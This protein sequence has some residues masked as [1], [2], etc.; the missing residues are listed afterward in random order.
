MI[1]KAFVEAFSDYQVQVDVPLWKLA[2]M[3]DRRSYHPELSYG[4]FLEGKLVGFVLNGYRMWQGIPTAYDVGTGV[5]PD[6]RRQ[7]LT[8]EML[9]RSKRAMRAAKIK[10]YLLEVI[11]T[12]ENAVKLY[13]EQGFQTIRTFTCFRGSVELIK[14]RHAAV[15]EAVDAIDF[16]AVQ[17]FGD[18]QPSWQNDEMAIHATPDQ[19]LYMVARRGDRIVGYGVMDKAT[20]DIAQIAVDMAYRR[21]G[22]GTD[23]IFCMADALKTDKISMLNIETDYLPLIALLEVHGMKAYIGQYEMVLEF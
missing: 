13:R 2:L 15:V 9:Q 11:D 21:Q 4:A 19:Y 23:L 3:L 1:H 17:A 5:V 6:A 22:I 12:N 10:R 18:I 7:G 14:P 16:R 8:S 20:G